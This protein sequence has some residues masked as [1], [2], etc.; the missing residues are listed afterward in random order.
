M[1]YCAPVDTRRDQAM[2]FWG[3]LFGCGGSLYGCGNSL[4][5]SVGFPVH[6][7]GKSRGNPPSLYPEWRKSTEPGAGPK[8]FPGPGNFAPPRRPTPNCREGYRSKKRSSEIQIGVVRRRR[9]AG[10]VVGQQR[11]EARARLDARVPFAGRLV[12]G[13]RHVTEI[14][15]ARQMR[16]RADVGNRELVARQPAP[17]LDQIADIVEMIRQIGVPG[18]NRL[19]TRLR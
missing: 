18:A 3:S 9:D 6:H 13:P 5:G 4:L 12:R 16:R 8:N 10:D 11:A 15:E 2:R 1:I 7:A 17:P 19:R 14:V